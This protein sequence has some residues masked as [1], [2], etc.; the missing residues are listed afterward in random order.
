VEPVFSKRK[1]VSPPSFNTVWI[2]P[3]Q[4]WLARA[5]IE[6]VMSAEPER[7]VEKPG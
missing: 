7:A 4:N 1:R 6:S 5:F 3:S 2:W